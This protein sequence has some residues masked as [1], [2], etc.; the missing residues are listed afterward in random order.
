MKRLVDDKA[1]RV[2]DVIT[3]EITL[4][5]QKKNSCSGLGAVVGVVVVDVVVVT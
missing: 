3:N 5:A 2:E 4:V 1:N